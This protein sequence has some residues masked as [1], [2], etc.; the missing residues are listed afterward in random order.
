MATLKLDFGRVYEN[1]FIEA[2]FEITHTFC[3]RTEDTEIVKHQG[4]L[5]QQLLRVRVEYDPKEIEYE[6]K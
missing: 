2:D 6:G 4:V 1:R 5:G 3:I